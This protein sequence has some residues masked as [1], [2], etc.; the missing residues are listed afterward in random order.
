[1]KKFIAM[2]LIISLAAAVVGCGAKKQEASPTAE[3]G[4]LK[5]GIVDGK[6]RFAADL[7]GAPVGIE[8]DIAKLVA[9]EGGYAIQF[10]S[11]ESTG[12][13]LH[14]VQSGEIDLGFG[15]IEETDKRLGDFTTSAGYGK[16]GLFLV[17][18]RNNYMDCLSMMQSGT[19]GVS[20]QAEP[21]KDEVEGIDSITTETYTNGQQLRDDIVSGKILAG[22]VSEREAVSMVGEKVQAQEL[23]NSP[24]E[25]YVAVMPKGS[26]LA[27]TVNLAVSKYRISGTGTGDQ[28]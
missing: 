8:A 6:D 24:K 20:S 2:V 5:V 15:R 18:P 27:D 26:S 11:C 13:L 9:D 16:G 1:M 22:L 17:T 7:S 12:A 21:L 3:S 23:L 19:L 14:G 25:T 10:E 4:V 28:E